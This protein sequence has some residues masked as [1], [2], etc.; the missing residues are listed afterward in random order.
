MFLLLINR[1]K[2][3]LDLLQADVW[4][5][6]S[7]WVCAL[8]ETPVPTHTHT[9]RR[10]GVRRQRSHSSIAGINGVTGNP[11]SSG[12]IR[13]VL[14]TWTQSCKATGRGR[15]AKKKVEDLNEKITFSCLCAANKEKFHNNRLFHHTRVTTLRKVKNGYAA[16]PPDSHHFALLCLYQCQQF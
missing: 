16:A 5:Q 14:P 13:S 12:Q 6:V 7:T 2:L 3:V 15:T 4:S 11:I 10:D 8:R 9:H 1:I